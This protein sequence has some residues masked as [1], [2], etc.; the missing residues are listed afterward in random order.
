MS[1][2]FEQLLDYLVNEEMDKANELFHE[3]VV[4]KSRTIYENLIADEDEME[5]G[6][7][8][9]QGN[10][11]ESIIAEFPEEIERFKQ[12]GALG[13]DLY[14]ALFDY[15]FEEMPY[16]IAKGRS[17]DPTEWVSDKLDRDLNDMEAQDTDEFGESEE[18]EDSFVMDAEEDDGFGG[19]AKGDATDKFGSEIGAD[20]DMDDMG[21]EGDEEQAMF[22]IKN[23]IEELEAAFAELEAAQG[24]EMGDNEFGDEE[25]DEEFG[26]EEMGDE[27]EELEMGMF[28]GRRLREYREAV[29][30]GHG[31]EKKGAAEGGI[32]GAN[33]GEKMPSGTNTRSPISSG[34]GK[35]ETGAGP[36]NILR[37]SSTTDEDGTS[38]RG[39]VGGLVKS[40]G[41]FTKGVEKNIASSAKA[42][43]K[44]G[45]ATSKQGS[46]YPGNN[47]T[48]G[49]VGSGSGDK[50]GQTSV[51]QV[52]S[53]L[54]GAP[55]RNA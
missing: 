10:D 52:K 47:K 45:S 13:D 50:A 22:D 11:F 42:S 6:H 21:G 41:Q 8:M 3:I 23:A 37:K 46:G 2:K 19:G 26:D 7:H 53:P 20:D 40:G 34:K 30:A 55:N 39:K 33:T 14:N 17:G 32:A 48:P 54:N 4:E 44:S 27:D 43:M 29:S 18:L 38:P 31:A 28:E 1:T 5:E 15:Y 9:S 36:G 12:G 24:G 51:G 16:G 35:P 49:P 25:G